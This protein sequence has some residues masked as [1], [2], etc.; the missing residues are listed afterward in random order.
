M[1][2]GWDGAVAA[3]KQ[4]HE[5]GCLY[6]G[7][8]PGGGYWL[9]VETCPLNHGQTCAWCDEHATTGFIGRTGDG[10][11]YAVPA[12]QPHADAWTASH[13]GWRRP[14]DEPETP[15]KTLAELLEALPPPVRDVAAQQ[16]RQV[17]KAVLY[18]TSSETGTPPFTGLV[19]VFGQPTNCVYPVF[20]TLRKKKRRM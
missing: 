14:D 13:S 6:G 18:D 20:D 12:C 1:Q 15:P 10:C 8:S 19:D 3:C 9:A 16:H 4:G 7:V 17:D 5:Q 11:L 2:P